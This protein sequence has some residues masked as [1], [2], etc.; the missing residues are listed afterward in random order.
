MVIFKEDDSHFFKEINLS[1]FP[2]CFKE[3]I[4]HRFPFFKEERDLHKFT[5]ESLVGFIAHS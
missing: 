1:S 4:C 2:L 5:P 3:V